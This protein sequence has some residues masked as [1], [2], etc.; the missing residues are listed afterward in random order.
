MAEPSKKD[1]AIA[2]LKAARARASALFGQVK[3][4]LQAG[5]SGAAGYYLA[6]FAADNI[7][8]VKK[9]WY[10]RGLALAGGSMLA[11]RQGMPNATLGLAGAA[12]YALGFHWELYRFQQGK[13]SA[14]PVP[15]F[16]LPKKEA[17][18]PTPSTSGYQ[19]VGGDAGAAVFETPD[20]DTGAEEDETGEEE[21]TGAGGDFDGGFDNPYP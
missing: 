20:V 8:F 7:D 21:E 11:K 4:Q 19:D 2:K 17:S 13:T 3:P 18:Q 15:T 12:G 10:G 16:N 6:E 14:S 5:G 9:E 1:L